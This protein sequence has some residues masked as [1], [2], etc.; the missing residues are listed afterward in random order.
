MI[1]KERA[2]RGRK[3]L[4]CCAGARAVARAV[5]VVPCADDLTFVI[6]N[7]STEVKFLANFVQY[8]PEDRLY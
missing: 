1:F 5:G 4:I 6:L 3:R 8:F 2:N 7:H